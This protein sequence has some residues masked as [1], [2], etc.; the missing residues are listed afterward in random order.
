MFDIRKN[1]FFIDANKSLLITMEH[2]RDEGANKKRR[3]V[4]VLIWEQEL[5]I[6]NHELHQVTPRLPDET[7]I[8]LLCNLFH[9]R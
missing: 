3:K 8:F 6:L 1:P 2:S 9:S 5:L 7:R 4:D